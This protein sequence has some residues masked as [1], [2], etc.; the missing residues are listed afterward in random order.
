MTERQ[1]LHI[2]IDA[3][4]VVNVIKRNMQGTSTINFVY[5]HPDK[6]EQPLEK[7]DVRETRDKRFVSNPFIIS[8][9]KFVDTNPRHIADVKR[10]ARE[11]AE[12]EGDD[13][14][15]Y[16]EEAVEV[17]EDNVRNMLQEEIVLTRDESELVIQVECE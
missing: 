12:Q 6:S 8:P 1:T 16:Q 13:P 15:Q 4:R 2:K 7:P 9:I 5:H 17:W 10:T 14:E 3:E 11:L